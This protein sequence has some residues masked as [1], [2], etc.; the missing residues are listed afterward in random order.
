MNSLSSKSG[1]VLIGYLFSASVEAPCCAPYH[2]RLSNINQPDQL[3][4]IKKYFEN[5]YTH[6]SC[7]HAADS[8]SLY[9]ITN[10]MLNGWW[11]ESKPH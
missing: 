10:N 1:K 3:S 11:V 8:E 9:N 6:I 7:T 4:P 5:K 2:W